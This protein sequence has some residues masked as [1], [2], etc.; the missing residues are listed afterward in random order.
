MMLTYESLRVKCN[1]FVTFVIKM[2]EMRI[3]LLIIAENYGNKFFRRKFMRRENKKVLLCLLLIAN[4]LLSSDFAT[5]VTQAADS[6]SEARAIETIN[7]E[8][9]ISPL[10]E[11]MEQIPEV[12]EKAAKKAAKEAK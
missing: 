3:L 4:L 5:I 9:T 6:Q 11:A 1:I 2:N 10:A 8:V 12:A 7:H